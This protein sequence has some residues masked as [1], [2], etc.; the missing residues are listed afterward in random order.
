MNS[1][2]TQTIIWVLATMMLSACDQPI[3]S[4]EPVA[5]RESVTLLHYFSDSLSGGLAEMTQLF[6]RNNQ[7]YELKPISLDH[8][9]FKSSIRDTLKQ[10]NPPDLYSYWAGA[11]TASIIDDLAPI[12]DIWQQAELDKLFS[13]TLTAASSEY[14]G[15]KYFLPLIQHYVGFYYNRAVFASL[16][17]SPPQ[18]WP[19]FLQVCAQLKQAGITPIALGAREKWPAQFWFDLI[20]LRIAPYELRH[21]LMQGEIS[22]DHPKVEQTFQIWA[23]LIQEG[24]FNEA[25]HEISWD[26]G[27]N[28]L[29]YQGKAAM[30]LMGTWNTAFFTNETHNWVVAEDFGFFVFPKIDPDL[31]TVS[32]GPIDGLVIPK[33]APN[34]EGAKDALVF[35]ARQDTQQAISK[36]SGALAANSQV[37]TDYYGLI[38]QQVRDEI[39]KSAFFAFNYDLS[40]PSQVAHLG[41]NAF[42]EFLAFPEA[43]R[44][45][46]KKLAMDT[47]K[48]FKDS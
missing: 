19:E 21:Q 32:L 22:Y 37:S 24:Y 1:I 20:L 42:T 46:I 8:E 47:Q 43:Y 29:V 17:L 27:A 45:I 2:K 30:T 28:E 23:K 16:N 12:D 10:G 11:R 44:E 14:G 3:S 31:P 35:L 39:D 41:L 13:S 5:A 48:A 25:P 34:P 18:T 9:A 40:T 38:Q 36:G 26:T 7:H 33:Q 15:K 4:Q 6:N